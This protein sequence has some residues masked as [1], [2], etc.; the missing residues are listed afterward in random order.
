MQ[1]AHTHQCFEMVYHGASWGDARSLARLQTQVSST[2]WK[3]T[4]LVV[5]K[6]MPKSEAMTAEIL[7]SRHPASEPTA[8]CHRN[9]AAKRRPLHVQNAILP[10]NE[11]PIASTRAGS[12]SGCWSKRSVA[13]R[14]SCV[15][16]PMPVQPG[17][18]ASSLSVARSQREKPISPPSA[19]PTILNGSEGLHML[20][21]HMHA[22]Q[23]NAT[24]YRPL[25]IPQR[26]PGPQGVCRRKSWRLP[27]HTPGSVQPSRVTGGRTT[28]SQG[29]PH[30]QRGVGTVARGR[31][32]DALPEIDPR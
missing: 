22:N 10:P 5:A 17:L 2:V 30:R 32:G 16:L 31:A 6:P 4:Q 9:V 21:T 24:S 3:R 11:C 29:A 27:V 12:T 8:T 13:S 19:S 20:A 1:A 25:C 15:S 7:V 26:S 28:A 23:E 14:T 18:S